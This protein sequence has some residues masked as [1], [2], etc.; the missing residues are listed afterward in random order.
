MDRAIYRDLAI[1]IA[2]GVAALLLF[3]LDHLVRTYAGFDDPYWW[4]HLIVDS[5]YIVL[6]GGLA[7][8]GV[9]G[10]RILQ[11][12]RRSRQDRSD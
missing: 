9:Q 1:S 10:W 12:R 5:S 3:H 11:A 6:C 7:F 4:L 8:V 2:V